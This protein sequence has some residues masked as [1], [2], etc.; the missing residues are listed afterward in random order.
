MENDYQKVKLKDIRRV[1]DVPNDA[2]E[3]LNLVGVISFSGP[4]GT[5]TEKISKVSGHY[6]CS[7]P[8]DDGSW[9]VFDD[10]IKKNIRAKES[11]P[12]APHFV[13]YVKKKKCSKIFNFFSLF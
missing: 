10:L 2:T 7:I 8:K 3:E 5:R 4:K 13:M 1:F 12:I 9:I 11:L 6:I